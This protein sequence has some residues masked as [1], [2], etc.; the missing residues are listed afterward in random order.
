MATLCAGLPDDSYYN[1]LFHDGQIKL[2]KCGIELSDRVVTVSPTY[3]QEVMSVEGGFG[4]HD[5]CANR[6]PHL[7]GILNGIDT[8]DWN[9]ATDAFLGAQ[10]Q[11]CDNY[12][13]AADLSGKTACKLHLQSCFH[14][15]ED[16]NIPIIA[17][18]GRLAYQ[19]G[20]D[21]LESVFPWLMSEDQSGVTGQVQVIMMGTGEDK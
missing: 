12:Y 8:N 4:L 16:R 2:L 7:D 20:L 5:R 21:I 15:P 19:K 17:F 18:V 9:P 3:K 10:Y 14:L 1:Y 13:S 11:G 6:M